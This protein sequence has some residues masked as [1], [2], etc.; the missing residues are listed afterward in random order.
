MDNSLDLN[1]IKDNF[2]K[3]EE[4]NS[5]FDNRYEL[6]TSQYHNYIY[7]EKNNKNIKYNNSWDFY[8][9]NKT[10]FDFSIQG[11]NK[12]KQEI[13]FF[14]IQLFCFDEK[15][16]KIKTNYILGLSN[17]NDLDEISRY[18]EKNEY[19]RLF[20]QIFKK[21]EL[22]KINQQN[23]F[24]KLFKH[25]FISCLNKSFEIG[26]I[27]NKYKRTKFIFETIENVID[28]MKE[29]GILSF[30]NNINENFEKYPEK[31]ISE[32][33][34]IGKKIELLNDE[35]IPNLYYELTELNNAEKKICVIK[36]Y[37]DE[38]GSY[39]QGSIYNKN[40]NSIDSSI[41]I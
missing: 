17:V 1:K 14:Y 24:F 32:D 34:L 31:N 19:I 28:N 25:Y 16:I 12:L 22:A 29:D 39:Y 20:C 23:E 15:E 30:I 2:G 38:N 33:K 13:F 6:N 8:F 36:E 9:T 10:K 37:K 18:C 26:K 41:D 40:N 3:S 5:I 4:F 21:E 7:D 35:K 27:K 11:L